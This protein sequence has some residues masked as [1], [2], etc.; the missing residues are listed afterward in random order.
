MNIALPFHFDSRGRTAHANLDAHLRDMLLMLLMTNPGER[1]NRSDF[2]GGLP[3]LVFSENL[4]ELQTTLRFTCQGAIMQYFGN[5]IDLQDLQV[6]VDGAELS[7][8]VTYT[9]RSS[10]AV[11]TLTIPLTGQNPD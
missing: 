11:N 5:S 10:T 2:G 3:S 8:T 1:V 9:R 7:V 4:I 6:I